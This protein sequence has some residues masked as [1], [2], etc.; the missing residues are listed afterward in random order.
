[1]SRSTRCREKLNE[2]GMLKW[3]RKDKPLRGPGKDSTSTKEHAR[4][5]VKKK[6]AKPTR[7]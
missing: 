4:T 5:V 2:T 6:N 1:M 3:E 7:S